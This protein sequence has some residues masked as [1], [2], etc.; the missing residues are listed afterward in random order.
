MHERPE[1]LAQDVLAPPARAAVFLTLT[2]RTGHEDDVRDALTDVPSLVRAV[3][4]REPELRLSCVTGIGSD[5]WARVYGD[6]PPPGGLHP[7]VR[8]EGARHTAIATPG[9]VLFHI[10]SARQ[11]LCFEL[12]HRLMRA[13]AG[14]V[15]VADETHGFRYFDSRDLLG[16]VDGTENPTPPSA[17]IAAALVAG[18]DV[19][20]GSSYVIVQKYLHDLV[21]WDA[22]P[23]EEQERVIGRTKLEDIELADDVKPSDS[24]VALTVIEEPD[25]TQLQIV[26]D[27]LA[28]GRVGDDGSGTYFI[29][30]AA[31]VAVTELMLERMFVGEPPGNHDR[32]LDF[33]TPVTGCLFFVPPAGFL[34][35]PAAYAPAGPPPAADDDPPAQPGDGSLGIGSMRRSGTP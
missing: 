6:V 27:N 19:W 23:V 8:V 2:V 1:D 12:A 22:L 34:E 33:S 24:H 3:G 10:R 14:H 29:G 28:F 25:G 21:A 32:I 30:Y 17:A 5:V 26:R 4:F 20:T 31:D 15:D 35:D 16:F 11:D 18:D 9:D 7:F 13:L